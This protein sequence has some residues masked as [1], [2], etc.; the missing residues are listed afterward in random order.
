M[1]E[2]LDLV[3]LLLQ[4]R[5]ALPG[6]HLQSVVQDEHDISALHCC[7]RLRASCFWLHSILHTFNSVILDSRWQ[8]CSDA[9]N[10]TELHAFAAP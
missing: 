2:A 4:A 9:V 6:Q 1:I 5:H 10:M 3:P 7:K 8:L